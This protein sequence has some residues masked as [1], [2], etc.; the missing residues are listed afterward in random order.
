MAIRMSLGAGRWRLVRQLLTESTLLALAGAVVGLLLA[1]VTMDLLVT[2]AGQFTTRAQEISLNGTV[3]LFTLGIA[4]ATGVLVGA[5]PALPGR[6]SLSSA[7]QD[8]GRT[9]S[10]GRG[11]LRSALIVAQVAVSFVLLIGAGLMLRSVLRLQSVDA[12]IRTD[13][14]LSMR[15]ALNFTKYTTPAL[16]AQFLTDLADRLRILPGV[17]SAGGAGTFPM[18]EG[19]GFLAS[20]RIE[21]QPEVD[22]ARLPRAD[23]QA[24][25]PGYFQTVGIPL[26][27]GRLLDDR[28]LADREPVA[29]ISDSMGRQFF[30]QAEAV[31]A[32]ISTD[33]GRTWVRIV[34][35][36][37]DV[38]STLASQPSQ[39]FYR[40]LA[41][42][43][44]LTVMFLARASGNASGLVQ[45]MRDAVHALDAHQPVDQF[46]TLDE[47]R[48]ASL[49]APRL[50]AMLIGV[51]AGIALL[52]T[53][54]GLAGVIGFLVNQRSQEFGV[55]MALGASRASVL[56]LVLGQGLRLVLLGL[57]LGGIAALA[58]SNTVRALL[59]DTEP[60]DIPTF[61]GV[62][63]VLAIV[64]LLACLLPA[65]RASSVDPLV[66]LRGN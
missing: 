64:A 14:V 10:A 60:T 46:R 21:G 5:I 34:G 44:L 38:R 18:N 55:R 13:S 57:V 45:Q 40:P 54:A 52:I 39:T 26:L 59:F 41:Q 4:M 47:V 48:S 43:P 23:V 2:L 65:R 66:V 61:A 8:G 33:N 7:I 42:A 1:S 49:S 20:V 62:A 24:A 3:L 37:G 35:I 31:G 29:V 30:P 25:T 50:T 17:R 16:R 53:A 63:A 51:F 58:L 6:I 27:R 12:G 28:D 9:V 19:G 36:V 11:S 15:V 56:Q 22:A 32:R